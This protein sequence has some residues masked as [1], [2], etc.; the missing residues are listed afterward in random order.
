VTGAAGFIGCSVVRRL[1][2]RGAEVHLLLRPDAAT[3]RLA[4]IGDVRVHHV[5]LPDAAAVQAVVRESAPAA[6][7]HLA[8][9]GAYESQADNQRILKSN[10]LGSLNI[11]EASLGAGVRVFVNLGSSS[12]YGVK[13]EAMRESDRLEPNSVY[14]VAKAAQ[15]HL[16][17]LMAAKGRMSAI[18]FRLFSVYGPWEEPDRL[19]PTV[20]RRARAGLPLEMASPDTAR[21]FVYVDDVVDA[22]VDFGRLQDLNGQI[23]NLGSGV[24]S[25]LRDVVDLVLSV[26]RSRSEVR[27]G[28]MPARRW[29]TNCWQA[30]ISKA[31]S[32]L[33]WEPRHTLREGIVRMA[34]W[35][36]SAGPAYAPP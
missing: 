20:I 12:E 25:T 29:D 31:R 10:I 4:D 30:D 23:F 19:I 14:A 18:T 35:M 15:T 3:W 6:V 9:H 1:L 21:D 7:V 33:G 17:T 24:Q 22:L 34:T 16:A 27:W 8:T 5:D 36:E 2:A 13:Q 28:A 11:M 26:A 32:D